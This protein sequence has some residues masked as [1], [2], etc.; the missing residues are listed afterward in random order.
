MSETIKKFK[1]TSSSV[2]ESFHIH[3]TR[4]ALFPFYFV[5][6]KELKVVWYRSALLASTMAIA[7]T[8][9]VLPSF[10]SLMTLIATGHSLTPQVVFTTILLIATVEI[11]FADYCYRGVYYATQFAA[12]L[13]R[14]EQFFVQDNELERQSVDS[15]ASQTKSGGFYADAQP[16]VSLSKVTSTVGQRGTVLLDDVSVTFQGSE[17]IGVVGP[18]G[19]GKSSLLKAIVGELQTRQGRMFSSAKSAYVPQIPWLFS[20]TIRDNIVFGEKYDH[21]KFSNIIEACALKEDL[22]RFPSEDL[23]FVGERGITLS[24]GQRARV[25]LARAI[26]SNADIYLLDDPFSAVDAKVGAHIVEKCLHGLL[27][28]KLIVLVTHRLRYLQTADRI[29]VMENGRIAK[30]TSYSEL[31]RLDD[32][33]NDENLQ[34]ETSD[35]SSSEDLKDPQEK[36]VKDTKE[37]EEGTQEDRQY[38][39]VSWRTYWNYLH[40]GNSV[41]FLVLLTIIVI[42]PEGKFVG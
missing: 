27:F 1:N 23:S 17:F 31:G 36:S 16:Y 11:T 25:G 26:Y 10:I 29:F 21:Q 38:G 18:I 4:L 14:L 12:T 19:S 22:E 8:C 15:K 6:S 7:Y 28:K 2:D 34:E 20:G 5:H 35:G 24:G 37:A 13:D 9:P 41:L 39:G 42:L 3:L 32:Q 30:E 33:H 40:A